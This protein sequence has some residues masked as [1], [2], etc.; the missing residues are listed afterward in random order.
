MN[1][2]EAFR[3]RP[4]RRYFI[5]VLHRG[6]LNIGIMA[7]L[8]GMLAIFGPLVTSLLAGFV[9]QLANRQ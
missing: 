3:L 5:P 7:Q 1:S 6:P 2:Q 9:P 4:G 8:S